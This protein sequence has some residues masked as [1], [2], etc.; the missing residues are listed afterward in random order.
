MSYVMNRFIDK[1]VAI[2]LIVYSLY[3]LYEG[4]AFVIPEA[5]SGADWQQYAMGANAIWEPE[6][7]ANYPVF[8]RPLY[9][10]L[11]GSL[12]YLDGVVSAGASISIFGM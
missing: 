6:T 1:A 5:P 8:R 10:I 9:M 4:G 3:W 11:L 2:S 12:S 7:G